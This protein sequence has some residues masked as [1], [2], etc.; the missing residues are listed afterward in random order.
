MELLQLQNE[1]KK[2][3]YKTTAKGEK[4]LEK[5]ADIA[6]LLGNND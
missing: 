3:T 4:Y 2:N 1:N 6:D 5:Y